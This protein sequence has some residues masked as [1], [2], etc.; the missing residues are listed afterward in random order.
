M[1]REFGGRD[2]DPHDRGTFTPGIVFVM[3][4]F[5]SLDSR[6]VFT[7]IKDECAA[8]DLRA[9]RVDEEGGS[10]F[11]IRDVVRMIEDAEFL[12]CDLSYERPNVYYELGYAHGVGNEADEIL[13]VAR[14]ETKLHFDI[15]P[16]RV[17]YYDDLAH[18]REILRRQL[19]RMLAATR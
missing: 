7:A 14:A 1:D 18:L 9:V 15:A 6:D 11:V 12:V 2:Y 5:Q 4:S 16:L 19:A 17:W 10:G 13:L 8:L 3:M